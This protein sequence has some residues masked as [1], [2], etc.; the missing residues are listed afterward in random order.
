LRC[1]SIPG[2]GTEFAIELPIQQ[3]VR[4]MTASSPQPAG[5]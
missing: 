4:D 3:Q 5:Y 1:T 2:K